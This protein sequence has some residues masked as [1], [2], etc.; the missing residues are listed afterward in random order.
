[1]TPLQA[2]IGYSTSPCFSKHLSPRRY[3]YSPLFYAA[4]PNLLPVSG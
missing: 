2:E 3:R 1:L 4:S